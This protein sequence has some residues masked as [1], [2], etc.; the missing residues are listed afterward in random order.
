MY[1]SRNLPEQPLI[2]RYQ[3]DNS[4]HTVRIQ[5]FVDTGFLNEF[6]NHL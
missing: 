4:A 1:I 6:A 2:K 3:Y 5:T